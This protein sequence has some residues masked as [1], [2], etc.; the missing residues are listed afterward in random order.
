MEI[1]LG[2]LNTAQIQKC[3]CDRGA[4]EWTMKACWLWEISPFL[5]IQDGQMNGIPCTYLLL[6]EATAS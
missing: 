6:D 1:S 5:G 2:I 4:N 3:E